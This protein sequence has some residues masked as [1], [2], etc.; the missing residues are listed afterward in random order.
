MSVNWRASI[1]YGIPVDF[2]EVEETLGYA[3]DLCQDFD[4]EL[5]NR[6]PLL[7]IAYAGNAFTGEDNNRY[8]VIKDSIVDA[9]DWEKSFDLN[10]LNAS[11][12]AE[13]VEQLWKFI[14]DT[15]VTIYDPEWRLLI[16]CG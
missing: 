10:K 2:K 15:G 9:W 12:N 4:T 11:M 6:Y 7:A 14:N 1:S 13:G 5:S 3:D 8:V 16:R